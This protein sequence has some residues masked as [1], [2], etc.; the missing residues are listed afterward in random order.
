MHEIFVS[1]FT[2]LSLIDQIS[3]VYLGISGYARAK[4][5]YASF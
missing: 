1:K 5:V 4:T 3:A 2:L